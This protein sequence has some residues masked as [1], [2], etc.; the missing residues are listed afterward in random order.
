VRVR[1]DTVESNCPSSRAL[2][3]G[4]RSQAAR[5]SDSNSTITPPLR[6]AVIALML[7]SGVLASRML[8]MASLRRVAMF[9]LLEPDGNRETPGLGSKSICRALMAA[10]PTA[11]STV[12]GR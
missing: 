3:S 8:L 7:P 4:V 5:S 2:A 12:G 11:W 9:L 6:R 10:L 1:N